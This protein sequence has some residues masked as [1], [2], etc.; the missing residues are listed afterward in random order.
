MPSR[1]MTINP[2]YN[3]EGQL[4]DF[5]VQHNHHGG[6]V[7]ATIV[8]DS[9]GRQQYQYIEQQRDPEGVYFDKHEYAGLLF[10]S[11]PGLKQMLE[12][13]NTENSGLPSGF[14]DEWNDII[15]SE[16]DGFDL[17][18][19]HKMLGILQEAYENADHTPPKSETEAW[20]DS[21][22]QEEVDNQVEQIRNTAVDFQQAEQLTALHGQV[23]TGSAE[24]FII[25]AG[26]DVAYGKASIEEKLQEAIGK[27]GA[28][29]A[30]KGYMTLS[31]LL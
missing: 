11:T 17:D 22:P 2:E 1:A 27:F 25:R 28:A 12:F 18:R 26:V 16:G 8:E 20:F 19:L 3:D 5:Q 9:Q 21:I 29:E 24:D 15:D 30:Y 6:Q 14:T 7:D 13:A 23:A 4:M 10:E 31:K